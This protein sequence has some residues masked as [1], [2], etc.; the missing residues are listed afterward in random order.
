M[1]APT[2]PRDSGAA[3]PRPPAPAGPYLIAG[4]GRAGRA[5]VARLVER[6]GTGSVAVWDDS[7]ADRVRRLRAA[8]AADGFPTFVDPI[9]ALEGVATVIR[10]PGVRIDHPLLTEARA[11]GIEVIDELELGWR[12]ASVPAV[13]VTG[14]NGKST[15]CGLLTAALEAAGRH[16][17]LCGNTL[18][19][20]PLSAIDDPA[21][22][23]LVAEVSSYQL[24]ACPQLLPSVAVLT[25]L[26]RD[27]LHRHGTMEAYAALKR[28]LFV[29]G[30]RA[31]ALAVLN[32]DDALGRELAG[33][34]AARGGRVLTYGRERGADY[35]IADATW[36]AA[37]ARVAI[38]TAAGSIEVQCRAPGAHNAANVAAALATADGI[39]L[40]R[41]STLEALRSTA[42]PPA[43][44]ER[45]DAGQPFEVIVDFGHTPDGVTQALAAVRP[46]VA[47][48][49]R[50]ITVLS[51]HANSELATRQAIGTAVRSRS[52]H[53]ILSAGSV[54]GEP[55]MLTLAQ[56]ATGARRA[57]HGTLAIRRHRSAAVAEAF[58]LARPGDVVVL[59][60][61]GPLTQVAYDHV[62]DPGY[63]DD[64]ALAREL[65]TSAGW[66]A[67]LDDRERLDSVVV[68]KA[69]QRSAP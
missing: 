42:P 3:E 56:L 27:H 49:A 44:F 8:F 33:A 61:R 68:G 2:P 10:S 40:E 60:G 19:G 62:S 28:R 15:T 69:E 25:N 11:R 46:L 9:A 26:T 50:L 1:S 4:L 18:I 67:E 66:T 41:E 23:W 7:R 64:R 45:V 20:P 29:R 31:V 51:A 5:A 52:D 59:L 30:D 16:P 21:V 6:D 35:R 14:T 13:A 34:V 57:R 63:S 39:G 24:E 12:L 43:R 37:E 58:A 36:T 53:T 47:P 17:V 55:P 48:G 65:L 22:D 38:E 54:K 32:A